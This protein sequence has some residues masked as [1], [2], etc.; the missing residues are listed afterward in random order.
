MAEALRYLHAHHILHRDVSA[1][2]L[3]LLEPQDC[4]FYEA[5]LSDFGL[6]VQLSAGDGPA[7]L[8]HTLCGTANFIAPEVAGGDPQGLAADRFSLGCLLYFLL[9]GAGPFQAADAA[10]AGQSGAHGHTSA[11]DATL[12]RVRRGEYTL[13]A[14]LSTSACDLITGLLQPRP[15]ERMGLAEVLR[16]RFLQ[17]PVT[18][19]TAAARPSSHTPSAAGSEQ[20]YRLAQASMSG[21][22]L[23]PSQALSVGGSSAAGCATASATA[24]AAGGAA[25]DV[26]PIS[27]TGLRP[28]QHA[29]GSATVGIL[30]GGAVRLRFRRP[31]RGLQQMEVSSDGLR[32]SLT[33]TA[34]RRTEASFHSLPVQFHNYYRYVSCFVELVRAKTPRVTL[35]SDDGTKTVVSSRR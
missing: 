12:A 27:T 11:L 20:G 8:H 16:H 5:K 33:A 21:P 6:A 10:V 23:L 32:V 28:V 25:P 15:A 30:P 22:P 1:C 17:G 13:P 35:Y 2:N 29:S 24:T 4:G 7:A 19:L 34:G 18:R 14:H 9:V 31:A 26:R 3:L